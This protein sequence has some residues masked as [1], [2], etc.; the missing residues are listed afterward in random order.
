MNTIKEL[1]TRIINITVSISEAYPELSKYLEENRNEIPNEECKE[2]T[3]TEL[4]EYLESLKKI[5]NTYKLA[6][7]NSL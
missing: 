3:K 6:H 4:Q 5:F 2:V 7:L 1:Y